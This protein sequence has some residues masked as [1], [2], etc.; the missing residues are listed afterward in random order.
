LLSCICLETNSSVDLYKLF[1]NE[2]SIESS[3]GQARDWKPRL[4]PVY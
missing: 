3:Y 1:R 2:I 4:N